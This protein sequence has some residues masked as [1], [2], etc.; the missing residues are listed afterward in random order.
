MY[1]I[2]QHQ[3]NSDSGFSLAMVSLMMSPIS[4]LYS[5]L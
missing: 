2:V 3:D 5:K 4:A 1:L